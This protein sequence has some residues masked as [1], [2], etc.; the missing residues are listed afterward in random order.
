MNPRFPIR[1]LPC[2]PAEAGA[3]EGP[4]HLHQLLTPPMGGGLA[5]PAAVLQLT[6][7]CSRN[8]AVLHRRQ[9]T[10]C[11]WM[12]ACLT[13]QVSRRT[14]AGGSGHLCDRHACVAGLCPLQKGCQHVQ[15][16]S[17]VKDHVLQSQADESALSP[18]AAAASAAGWGFPTADR[19]LTEL[20]PV[21]Q[22]KHAVRE[23]TS[24][25]SSSLPMA[26]HHRQL[27]VLELLPDLHD[28]CGLM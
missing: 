15:L 10:V 16:L 22:Q 18:G 6:L 27:P 14:K 8:S 2:S 25:C 17:A 12:Q 13:L 11:S 23:S 5:R 28:S 24:S 19:C 7:W 4:H 21:C 3:H 1:L 26:T 20:L 9:L